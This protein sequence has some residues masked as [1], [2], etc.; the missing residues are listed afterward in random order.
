MSLMIMNYSVLNTIRGTMPEEE[1]GKKFLSQ[2][3]NILKRSKRVPFLVE[4]IKVE[5]DPS[6]SSQSDSQE[7]AAEVI[8]AEIKKL[9]KA[10]V[11]VL[12][13]AGEMEAEVAE[14]EVEER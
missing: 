4:F 13:E 1:N 7:A 10:L 14:A 12:W 6:S 3:E 5:L 9:E 8:S 2:I 11:G